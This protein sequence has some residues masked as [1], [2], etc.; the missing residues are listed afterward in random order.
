MSIPRTVSDLSTVSSNL[1]A[2]ID[3]HLEDTG[4]LLRLTP[5]RVPRSFLQPDAPAIE[6]YRNA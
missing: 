6:A 2:L 1:K 5:D 4:G 3:G